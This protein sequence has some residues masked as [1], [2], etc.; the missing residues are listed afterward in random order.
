MKLAKAPNQK[1]TQKQSMSWSS[2]VTPNQM[3]R[4]IEKQLDKRAH[5]TKDPLVKTAKKG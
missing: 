5:M 3:K 1:P 4:G 2:T